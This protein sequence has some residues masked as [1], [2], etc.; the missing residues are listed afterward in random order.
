MTE[1]LAVVRPIEIYFSEK[2]ECKGTQD[3]RE[4]LWADYK[5]GIWN[6]EYISDALKVHTSESGMQGLG[7][8]EYRQVATAFMEKH[9]KYKEEMS[10]CVDAILDI[11]AG[12]SSRTAGLAYAIAEGDHRSV[13]R[14]GM[15]RFYIASKGWEEWR[16]D[17]YCL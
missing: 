4:L 1:Y 2:F 8:R 10:I 16:G 17:V 14:E 3:L 5:K 9:L 15:H 11:Q 7:F 6:G 13:S 12:H